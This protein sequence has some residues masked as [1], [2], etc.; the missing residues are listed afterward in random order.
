MDNISNVDFLKNLSL[1][2]QPL[3]L[4]VVVWLLKS[5]QKRDDDDQK[6]LK[7]TVKTLSTDSVIIKKDIEI[8]TVKMSEIAV[9][10]KNLKNSHDEIVILKRDMTTMWKRLDEIKNG[11]PFQS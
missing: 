1:A 8:M 5:R 10:L 6:E 4:G 7:E 2:V 11:R 3:L 9:E